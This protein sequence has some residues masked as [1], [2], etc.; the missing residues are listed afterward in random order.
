MSEACRANIAARLGPEL[1]C[2]SSDLHRT[3]RFFNTARTR[4]SARSRRASRNPPRVWNRSGRM[5]PSMLA[6]G[7]AFGE[8][9]QRARLR[10]AVSALTLRK[11]RFERGIRTTCPPTRKAQ[12][13]N[14]RE[15][16]IDVQSALLRLSES[17]G[18]SPRTKWCRRP[19]ARRR[20][21]PRCARR[22][23]CPA[24]RSSA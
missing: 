1:P 7:K 22:C 18:S 5:A 24:W 4:R 10:S 23:A 3:P 9:W 17:R 6:A 11:S 8:P 16:R 15:H 2:A 21:P 12:P 13:G 19:P 14:V 20:A